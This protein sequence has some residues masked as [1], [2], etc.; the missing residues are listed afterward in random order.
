MIALPRKNSQRVPAYPLHALKGMFWDT[1]CD[2]QLHNEPQVRK[3]WSLL[4][5]DKYL[6]FIKEVDS[7]TQQLYGSASDHYRWNQLAC[8][9]LKYPFKDKSLD[10]RKAAI[11]KFLRSEHRCMRL[12][13]I[14]RLRRNMREKESTSFARD[15]IARVLGPFSW[16]KVFEYCD[17]GPGSSVGVHG[18]DV[19]FQK[20]LANLTVTPALKPVALAALLNHRSYS[21]IL[22]GEEPYG[23]DAVLANH[24]LTE[25]KGW[26]C[27]QH[28]KITCVPKNAKTDRTI[29]IE[30]SLNGFI[31]KGI[32]LF[33]RSRLRRVGIDL[34]NQSHNQKLAELASIHGSHATIDLS[35]ASDSISIELVRTLLPD[36]WFQALNLARSPSYSL[37]GKLRRYHK[38]CSMG[39][40]FCFPLESLIFGA[41]C[42]YCKS[43]ADTGQ[44][45]VYGDDLIVPQ[46]NALLLFEV[47]RDHGFKPNTDKTFV[48]GP[49]RESCGADFYLGTNVRPIYIKQELK[50]PADIYPVLNQWSTRNGYSHFWERL[51]HGLSSKWFLPYPDYLPQDDR[52]IRVPVDRF[53][54]SRHAVWNRDYQA[55]SYTAVVRRPSSGT[56]PYN[57]DC[58]LAGKLRGDLVHSETFT[59]RFKVRTST[60]KSMGVTGAA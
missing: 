16:A 59:H 35:M 38:F 29:A 25:G 34:S 1:A 10:R 44:Y 5:A 50:H 21:R 15:W 32:D 58:L 13:Q 18:Q 43:K 36:D 22:F 11:D 23:L 17:F 33:M 30:P 39:N 3:A 57:E 42:E 2:L 47:L 27:V 28:N 14:F 12:N 48:F 6:S 37:D 8:L 54:S 46:G 55:W 56:R 51:I 31:Q 9:L 7:W 26:H 45:L 24:L 60:S 52:A 19:S 4:Q 53:M 40:G 41:F 20:K 49:F